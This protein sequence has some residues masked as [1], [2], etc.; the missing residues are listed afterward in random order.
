VGI[1]RLA[2]VARSKG[3]IVLTLTAA[4]SRV[5]AASPAL[6]R[7]ALWGMVAPLVAYI[8]R[9]DFGEMLVMMI[10]AADLTE[11]SLLAGGQ[12]WPER[13]RRRPGPLSGDDR[14][15]RGPEHNT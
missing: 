2:L 12:E 6:Q 7:P 9:A 10:S 8:D 1:A 5:S 14:G 4:R 3:R 13:M 11:R 15:R